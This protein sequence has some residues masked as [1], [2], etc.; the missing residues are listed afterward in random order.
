MRLDKFLADMGAGTRSQIKEAVRR[1]RVTVNGSPA[2]QADV[3][4]SDTDVV[5][6]D[7]K[8]VT[9]TA[10]EYYMLY[11]PAGVLSAS[12]DPKAPT[13]LDLITDKKRKDLF[14]VGRLDKDTEGLLLISN[15]GELAHRLL[16]PKHHIPKVYFAR[17]DGMIT[18]EMKKKFADGITIDEEFQA[19]PAQMKLLRANEAQSEAELTI[20][21]GKFHQV[22]RMFEAVGLTV[23]YLKRLSMGSLLL[24]E[25]LGKGGFRPLSERELKSLKKD[26]F[27]TAEEI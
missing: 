26:A 18:E 14:P 15:D 9:Y 17:V 20:Y 25:A 1:G 22:K 21:E 10:L 5:L 11:K 23:T 19:L 24:D 16:S 6:L 13:V 3:K 8:Q 12:R 2:R 4:V 7:G 27:H